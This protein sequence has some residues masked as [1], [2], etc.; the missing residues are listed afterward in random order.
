MGVA[1]ARSYLTT[2]KPGPIPGA[3]KEYVV[4]ADKVMA[5][6][7]PLLDAVSQ[8]IYDYAESVKDTVSDPT[9][10]DD[11]KVDFFHGAGNADLGIA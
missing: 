7:G 10:P 5:T 1:A 9:K 3:V 11:P 6:V 8:A 4:P 2:G